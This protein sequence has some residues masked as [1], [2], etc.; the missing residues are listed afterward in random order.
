MV[1]EGMDLVGT[2]LKWMLESTMTRMLESTI[3]PFNYHQ[4]I[5]CASSRKHLP[6]SWA[7]YWAL[8][9]PLTPGGEP[10]YVPTLALTLAIN[11]FPNRSP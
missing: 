9:A 7:W 6:Q 4:P 8:L 11:V 10:M 3:N 1:N 2:T 5:M